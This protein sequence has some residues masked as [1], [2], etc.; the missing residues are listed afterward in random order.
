MLSHISV[1]YTEV[2]YVNML[3]LGSMETTL[4]CTSGTSPKLVAA[5]ETDMAP[6]VKDVPCTGLPHVQ[7]KWSV[8]TK[9]SLLGVCA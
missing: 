3:P 7:K 2:H 4:L 5:G 9:K 6:A 1:T 8:N